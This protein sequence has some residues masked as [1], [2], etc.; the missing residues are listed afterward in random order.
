MT[1]TSRAIFLPVTNGPEKVN[2]LL[3]LCCDHF[4]RGLHLLIWTGSDAV[5]NYVDELL[6]KADFLPHGIDSDELISITSG[7]KNCNNSHAVLNLRDSPV[8]VAGDLYSTI[9]ELEDGTSE[10]RAIVSKSKYTFYRRKGIRIA[11]IS[12]K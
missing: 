8:D 1:T 4:D 9:Y 5:S 3:R 2:T 7:E 11:E 12:L 10:A 6:W